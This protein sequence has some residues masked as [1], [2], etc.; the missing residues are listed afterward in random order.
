MQYKKNYSCLLLE[1]YGTHKYNVWTKCGVF[2][3]QTCSSLLCMCLE[4]IKGIKDCQHCRGHIGDFALQMGVSLLSQ[5][6]NLSIFNFWT[7]GRGIIAGAFVICKWANVKL[8]VIKKYSVCFLCFTNIKLYLIKF[9]YNIINFL[10][11]EERTLILDIRQKIS[12]FF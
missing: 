1:P 12:N 6:V 5:T 11:S 9:Q 8:T 4:V 10:N 3:Y 7:F 2:Y